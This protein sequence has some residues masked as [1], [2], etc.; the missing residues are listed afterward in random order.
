[1]VLSVV[2]TDGVAL[3]PAIRA[4]IPGSTQTHC[5]PDCSG[6]VKLFLRTLCRGHF[7][8]LDRASGWFI[9]PSRAPVACT[10]CRTQAD[11]GTPSPRVYSLRVVDDNIEGQGFRMKAITAAAA[12]SL[13]FG[14]SA[15]AEPF[16]PP[17]RGFPPPPPPGPPGGH[18][19]AAPGPVLGAGLPVLALGAGIYWVARRRRKSQTANS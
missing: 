2:A 11:L 15:T 10:F 17:G 6:C 5:R 16:G 12:L 19:H 4:G 7:G 13:L 9:I 3:S 8:Y 1:M 14:L 18:S